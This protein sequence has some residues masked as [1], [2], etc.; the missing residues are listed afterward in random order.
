MPGLS[1]SSFLLFFF[2]SSLPPSL[3]C[4]N[5]A[6]TFSQAKPLPAY[7]NIYV[8][9]YIFTHVYINIYPVSSRM[10]GWQGN[11]NSASKQSLMYLIPLLIFYRFPFFQP[12][13]RFSHGN[14]VDL[15]AKV[16]H[17]LFSLSLQTTRLHPRRCKL[18]SCFTSFCSN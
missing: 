9:V 18:Q 2:S 16:Q 13:S 1:L 14:Q 12:K 4:T 7:S 10:G 6:R 15:K 3:L 5:I 17:S 11:V 8:Y